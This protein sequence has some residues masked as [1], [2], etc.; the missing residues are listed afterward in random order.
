M[1]QNQ[2]GTATL[3]RAAPSEGPAQT[4]KALLLYGTIAGLLYVVL[5]TAQAL[6][7]DGFDIREHALSLLSNGGLGWI[8]IVNF[9]LTGALTIVAAIGVRRALRGEPGGTWAPR[10]IALYGAG[11]IAAGAFRADPSFGFPPG[12]PDGQGAVTWHGMLHLV[13]GS[14]GFVG[15]IAACLVLARHFTAVGRPGWAVYSRGTGIFFLIAF[16]GI[17]SG[18]GNALINIGFTVAIAAGWLW[19]AAATLRL[20]RE[21]T[22]ASAT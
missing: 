14:V 12:T 18:A 6:F 1:T 15:L 20:R 7:R 17:A 3:T 11:L 13:S 21:I 19:L 16:I 5:G 2:A 9:L 4:T 22:Q 10:M 8:Q